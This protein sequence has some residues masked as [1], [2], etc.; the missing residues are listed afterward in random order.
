MIIITSLWRASH[1]LEGKVLLI[2]FPHVL[3]G[4]AVDKRDA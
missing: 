1:I 3:G 4:T 2:L